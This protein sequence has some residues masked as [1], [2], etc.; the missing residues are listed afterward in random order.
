MLTA[1]KN[2]AV[3]LEK[4]V[5]NMGYAENQQQTVLILIVSKAVML[6]GPAIGI[7]LLMMNV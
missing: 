3:V 1:M 6:K 7:I 4:F 2:F 5:M